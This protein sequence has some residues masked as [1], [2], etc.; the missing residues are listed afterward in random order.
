M[1]GWFICSLLAIVCLR[2]WLTAEEMRVAICDPDPRGM[3]PPSGD[4]RRWGRPV[5][6]R[7]ASLVYGQ[8][9][10]PLNT[11]FEERAQ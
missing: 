1:V 3:I 11:G 5:F 7:L 6:L 10:T 9:I 4:I 2:P 8:R